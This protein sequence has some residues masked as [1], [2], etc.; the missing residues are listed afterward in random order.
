MIVDLAG[1]RMTGHVDHD[2]L[3]ER[4]VVRLRPERRRS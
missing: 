3:P 4:P 1:A 2:G